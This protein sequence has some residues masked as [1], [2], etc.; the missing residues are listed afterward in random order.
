MHLD[1]VRH[2][3]SDTSSNLAPV[4]PWSLE[5]NKVSDSDSEYGPWLVVHRVVAVAE[6]GVQAP[7]PNAMAV[8][9]AVQFL[10]TH[11][12]LLARTHDKCPQ[13]KVIG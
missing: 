4:V 13:L 9:H 7:S 11:G 10:E 2:R 1:T 5:E 3:N 6:E 8:M 12:T